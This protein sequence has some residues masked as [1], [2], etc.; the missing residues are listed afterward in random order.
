MILTNIKIANLYCF[1]DLN[2][3]FTFAK[4][5]VS[6]TLD[7]EFLE[8]RPK[9]KFKRFCILM[10]PNSVGKSAFAKVI[11]AVNSFLKG[12]TLPATTAE[13]FIDPTKLATL[14]VE[15]VTPKSLFIHI[16]KLEI[17]PSS[18][19]ISSI[20]Y[21]SLPILKSDTNTICR[22]KLE[23]LMQGE[24]FPKSVVIKSQDKIRS[25]I[26]KLKKID[27]EIEYD[28]EFDDHAFKTSLALNIDPKLV[29]AL[30]KTFEPNVTKVVAHEIA[31]PFVQCTCY[32]IEF[33]NKKSFDF[34]PIS[35]VTSAIS[36]LSKGTC[37]LLTA[38]ECI[39]KIISNSKN[40]SSVFYSLDDK[41]SSCDS[42][43]EL[44]I[45]NLMVSKLSRNSQ[46][47]YISHNNDLLGIDFPTHSFLFLGRGGPLVKAF[48]PEQM[49]Y[50][51]NDRSLLSLVKNNC[52]STIPNTVAIDELFSE[53]FVGNSQDLEVKQTK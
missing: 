29:F 16:L 2:V 11:Y 49:G 22:E 46:L 53:E 17:A 51:K 14:E 19:K 40:E 24:E 42:E 36:H 45:L 37:Q 4:K 1:D 3:D 8:N 52:F 35:P 26:N 33:S 18:N 9:F 10:G 39:C 43:L 38:M 30:I 27:F 20:E 7:D 15:F 25:A 23:K 6:S 32:T 28:F 21:A 50:S 47:L 12:Y 5:I 41:L 34:Y 48:L 13:A 31:D 44:L